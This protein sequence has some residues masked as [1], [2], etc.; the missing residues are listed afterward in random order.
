[1]GESPQKGCLDRLVGFLLCSNNKAAFP[2]R[3]SR[4]FFPA[5][6]FLLLDLPIN[7]SPVSDLDDPDR[8]SIVLNGV[9]YPVITLSYPP[10]LYPG[11]L[12]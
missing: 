10:Q 2:S 11:K 4:F 1:V 5:K 7:L 9:N 6:N 8:K 3:E 12:L